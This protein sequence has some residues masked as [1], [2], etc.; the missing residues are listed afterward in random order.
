MYRMRKVTIAKTKG[1]LYNDTSLGCDI[2]LIMCVRNKNDKESGP[3]KYQ[4]L[5]L[6]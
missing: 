4:G 1:Y 2:I 5:F 6:A 3:G